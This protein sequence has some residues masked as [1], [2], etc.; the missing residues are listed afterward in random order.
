MFGQ[1]RVPVRDM[2]MGDDIFIRGDV[3]VEKELGKTIKDKFPIADHQIIQRNA[4]EVKLQ[5]QQ[6][7]LS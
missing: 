6:R 5:N 3:P 4:L 7:R 1:T 2:G